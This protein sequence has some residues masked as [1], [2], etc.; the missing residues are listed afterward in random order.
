MEVHQNEPVDNDIEVYQVYKIDP[1]HII[2]LHSKRKKISFGSFMPS[3]LDS[4]YEYEINPSETIY[5]Y[6]GIYFLLL[7]LPPGVNHHKRKI[8][9][10]GY[11]WTFINIIYTTKDIG[12]DK[13]SENIRGSKTLDIKEGDNLYVTKTKRR[14]KI[15]FD[16]K[17]LFVYGND[18]VYKKS[19]YCYLLALA[20]DQKS[21]DLLL[22]AITAFDSGDNKRMI[23]A[24]N[25]IYAFD[26]KYFFENPVNVSVYETYELWKFAER[27]LSVKSKHDEI[28]QQVAEL[29]TIIEDRSWRKKEWLLAVLGAIIAVASLVS[30][31][32]DGKELLGL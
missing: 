21:R 16:P 18:S 20:Y 17:G 4:F 2:G 5:E 13:I 25:D 23:D 26:L 29:A 7:K 22:A 28:R 12:N 27:T 10:D 11:D 24:R 15:V 14:D 8:N 3:I 6:F 32:N 1:K 9:D 31:I 19:L 30:V